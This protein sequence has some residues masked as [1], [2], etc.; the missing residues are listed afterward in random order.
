MIVPGQPGMPNSASPTDVGTSPLSQQSN[1]K[2]SPANLL[3]AAATMKQLG[4]FDTGAQAPAQ[5]MPKAKRV[6]TR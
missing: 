2:A 1:A 3:M 6:H 5:P 4:R